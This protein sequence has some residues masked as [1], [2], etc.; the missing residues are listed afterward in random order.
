MCVAAVEADE[1]ND[2][3]QPKFRYGF[4]TVFEWYVHLH[5]LVKS[6][7]TPCLNTGI[8]NSP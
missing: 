4:G 3:K 1:E 7:T 5:K 2:V 8:T 6:R